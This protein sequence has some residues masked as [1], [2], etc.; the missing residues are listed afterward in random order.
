M[1]ER[2]VKSVVAIVVLSLSGA[3]MG[4]CDVSEVFGE[5]VGY[6]VGSANLDVTAGDLNGDGAPD[7]VVC[8][9]FADPDTIAVLLNNG[10]GTFGEATEYPLVGGPARR[11]AIGD[12][13][14]DGSP[15]LAVVT[16]V[17]EVLLGAGDGT[18]GAPGTFSSGQMYKDVECADMDGDGHFDIIAADR[19]FDEFTIAFGD[20]TG[21]FSVRFF[22]AFD[23][24]TG[25]E[26]ADFNNDGIL[27]VATSLVFE[28]SG[29]QINL[30]EGDRQFGSGNVF[31]LGDPEDLTSGDFDGDGNVD[32]AAQN[33]N[34]GTFEVLFGNGDGTFTPLV[35][36]VVPGQDPG[37][38][39]PVPLAIGAN[40]LDGDG[41][42][43]I[44]TANFGLNI[45]PDMGSS[46]GVALSNGDRTFEGPAL[47]PVAPDDRTGDRLRSTAFA[48]FDGDGTLDLAGT[49][50]ADVFVLLNACGGGCAADID[51]DG[52]ADAD[53]FF[54][55]L[56]LFAAG[57]DLADI[58]GDGDTD[59]DDFFGYLDLFAAGC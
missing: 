6:G 48:D 43:D 15:D 14:E 36:V 29:V 42:D 34:E 50:N 38:G 2:Q 39:F 5:A 13:D 46:F 9:F 53:D 27:D 3:A 4:Q 40:D 52:D 26:I 20:G 44:V 37:S 41:D 32:L 59:A 22:T 18:F 12:F 16:G 24:P 31:E 30:G 23:G 51:G 8:A 7:L 25:V 55:Y 49:A 45:G 56:D 21:D 35:S 28:P 54:G 57:D 10:D 47:Y 19:D 58:D 1:C 11:A 17:I 33:D